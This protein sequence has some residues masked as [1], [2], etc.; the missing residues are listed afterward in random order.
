MH[1]HFIARYQHYN[2]IYINEYKKTLCL[3]TSV[4]IN[5]VVYDESNSNGLE[6]IKNGSYNGC[7]SI[8]QIALEF[9]NAVTEDINR[10]LCRGE[11]ILVNGNL[12]NENKIN[13]I[14]VIKNGSKAGC[15]SIIYVNLEYKNE[16]I[17]NF[18]TILCKGENIIINGNTYNELKPMGVEILS[19]AGKDGCDSIININLSFLNPL[20]TNFNKKI[21][22]NETLTINGNNYNFSNP[23]GTEVFKN[24][25]A[26]GCDSIVNI[27][28]EFFEESS[29]NF[30]SLICRGDS[31]IINNV[32]YKQGKLKGIEIIPNAA[33]N[34]C[35][36]VVVVDIEFLPEAE[37]NYAVQICESENI[38]ING[39]NYNK[40]KTAGKEILKG[41]A[42]N[43]CDSII[44]VQLKIN[45]VII[46]N[47]NYLICENDSILINGKIYSKDN[48]KGTDT[49]KA[50]SNEA[51][52]SIIRIKIELIPVKT[53]Y[54]TIFINTGEFILINGNKYDENKINGIEKF[55]SKEG[56]D[57]IVFIYIKIGTPILSIDYLIQQPGCESDSG[58]LIIRKITG[59]KNY[60][61]LLNGNNYPMISFPFT[62]KGLASGDYK[63]EIIAD[64]K[65]TFT[66]TF[67]IDKAKPFILELSQK[68]YIIYQNQKQVLDCILNKDI[69]EY[70]WSPQDYLS[71]S[72]CKNPELMSI[73]SNMN[74]SIKVKNTEGCIAE[75]I[76]QIFVLK[77]N[78]VILPNIIKSGSESNGVLKILT[79]DGVKLKQLS[80]FDRWG[81]LVFNS[82]LTSSTD[83]LKS[84]DGTLNGEKLDPG[85]YVYTLTY[86]I[87]GLEMRKNGDITL[88]K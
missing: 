11:S 3:G 46:E 77:G 71:C 36:S 75:D 67:R 7:D 17:N 41:K 29:Y 53:N 59:S 56:C 30:N 32:I 61:I 26:S 22:K 70:E 86:T 54:D 43:G 51:C 60:T 80:I 20:V 52:D 49:L 8:I 13:G 57:S 25:A 27:F 18:S 50:L 34:G 78:E 1:N 39:T 31:V 45:P 74:Y 4:I 38:Q 72:D 21:C 87:N 9:S 14:E 81:N 6:I 33:V 79:E 5:G 44:N 15:D 83:V 48:T 63:I 16:A 40:D 64:Y 2:F 84:L 82:N 42:S 88:I 85:V 12:Y 73:S 69:L 24:A 68:T 58:N 35:D 55:I 62:F 66:T 47:L 76:I 37:F 19:N 23:T 65:A 10:T 28:L